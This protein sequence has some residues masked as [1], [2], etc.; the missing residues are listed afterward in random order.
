MSLIAGIA[1][2]SFLLYL[3]KG[4]GIDLAGPVDFFYIAFRSYSDLFYRKTY[5]KR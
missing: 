4:P 3:W 1:A 2:L 5:I